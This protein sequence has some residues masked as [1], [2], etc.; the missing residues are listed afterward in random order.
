[1]TRHTAPYAPRAPRRLRRWRATDVMTYQNYALLIIFSKQIV[2]RLTVR[3]PHSR[4]TDRQSSNAA[5][6]RS[7]DAHLCHRLSSPSHRARP[8]QTLVALSTGCIS[9]ILVKFSAAKRATPCDGWRLAAG[10]ICLHSKLKSTKRPRR[11][12]RGVGDVCDV[13]FARH[14]GEIIFYYL[15]GMMFICC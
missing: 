10:S 3:L 7:T 12:W 9:R 4:N 15:A 11:W 8:A 14:V 6:L 1:M 2:H 5:H 13:A